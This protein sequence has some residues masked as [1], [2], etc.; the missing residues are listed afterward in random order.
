MGE[1]SDD[2]DALVVGIVRRHVPDLGEG[3]VRAKQSKQGKYVSVTV[4][5]EATSREQLDN[6][7]RELTACEQ[8]RMVL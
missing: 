7:Y 3:A 8:V 1:A 5:F 4:S 6:L 2:F